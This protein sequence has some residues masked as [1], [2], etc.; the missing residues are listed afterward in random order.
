MVAHGLFAAP[1]QLVVAKLEGLLGD[2]AQVLLDGELVLRGRRHDA[3]LQ[4][5][6]ASSIS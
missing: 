6:P 1:L 5:V 2:L 4:M 3:G